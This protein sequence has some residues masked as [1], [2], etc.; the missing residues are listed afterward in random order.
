MREA[1]APCWLHTLPCL[2]STVHPLQSQYLMWV[3]NEFII[4]PT[5]LFQTPESL[6]EVQRPFHHPSPSPC[7]SF[8]VKATTA[9][10]SPV[11]LLKGRSSTEFYQHSNHLFKVLP[12]DSGYN[13]DVV[14]PSTCEVSVCSGNEE[15]CRNE[16]SV[17]VGPSKQ[18]EKTVDIRQWF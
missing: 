1:W 16:T 14:T 8:N 5:A 12:N 17:L 9:V 15:L 2:H 18:V 3:C 10:M 11:R 6:V 13:S 4:A 7:G